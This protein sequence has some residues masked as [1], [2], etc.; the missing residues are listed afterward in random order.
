MK[1]IQSLLFLLLSLSQLAWA[2]APVNPDTAAQ[3]VFVCQHGSAKSMIAA[4]W[5]NK[6]AEQRGLAVRAIS[7]GVTPD[8][9]LHGPTEQGLGRD[10][11]DTKALIPTQLTADVAGKALRV[12]A[13]GVENK[14]DFL[15]TDTL[16]EWNNVPSVG[17]NYD[18]AREDM[19]QKI[20][21]LISQF[22][23]EQG[24]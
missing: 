14:P 10:G 18:R 17:Q 5:F 15:K 11:L 6:I 23:A 1:K 4:S 20:N 21:T 2:A 19:V 22:Q 9:A 12:V 7:R 8:T 16:L 13:I 24:K 3:V